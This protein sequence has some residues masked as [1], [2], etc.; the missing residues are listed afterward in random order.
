MGMGSPPHEIAAFRD[1]AGLRQKLLKS[2]QVMLNFYGFRL[3]AEGEIVQDAGFNGKSRRWIGINNHNCL[4]ISRIL[5]GLVLLGLSEY[6]RAL[7][8]AL[9]DVYRTHAE[10][11]G[12][13]TLSYWD[14]AVQMS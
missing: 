12:P 14:R 9:Q 2:L 1:D 5:S 11:I 7:H 3:T 10:D 8:R 6:A 4:R 13:E